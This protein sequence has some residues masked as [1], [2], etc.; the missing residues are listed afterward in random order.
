[1]PSIPQLT[2]TQWFVLAA[3]WLGWVFDIMDTSL[4]AFAKTPMLT[5]MLG[6]EAAY[7]LHGTAI[8]GRIQSFFMVGWAIGGFVFGV[9]ADKWGRKPT[10]LA[11]IGIYCTLTGL[12]ALCRTPDQV[13]V[14]RFL[15][16]LGIGG[17]WAAG[18]ALVAESMPD[19]FRARAATLIQSA[20]AFGPVFGASINLANAHWHNDWRVLFLAGI[21]PGVVCIFIRRYVPEPVHTT[22]ARQRFDLGEFWR[23]YALRR[24]LIVA[25]VIGV[26][27]ITGAGTVPF[28]LQNLVKTASPGMSM[29]VVSERLSYTQYSLHVGTLL[30]VICA[31]LIAERFGRRRA[32]IAYFLAAPASVALMVYGGTSYERLLT[33]SPVSSFFTIGV[34]AI[35]VLYFPELFPSRLRATG[36]GM[37]YNSG[38]ILSSPIPALTGHI[39]ETTHSIEAGILAASSVYILG[40]VAAPFARE[41]KGDPLP[42]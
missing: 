42:D 36:A 21:A 17:E 24:N 23:D 13:L 34:S 12:T 1:M 26:V 22:S 41:T 4:F 14:M 25:C 18:A 20:S 30:G 29:T 40:L 28:W 10:L 19:A 8:E 11:T 6:G 37:A 33:L 27:G 15:T 7:K 3:A 39:M 31:P 5:Q 32:I 2:R 38:R 9:L 35:F 16:A